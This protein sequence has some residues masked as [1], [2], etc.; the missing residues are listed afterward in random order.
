MEKIINDGY[1]YLHKQIEK[2]RE[3][4]NIYE[5]DDKYI[6]YYK[7]KHSKNEEYEYETTTLEY[8]YQLDKYVWEYD[9]WE[10][11]DYI[12]LVGITPVSKLI[13]IKPYY[14]VKEENK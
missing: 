10:G 4:K 2:L 8:D 11:E 7:L 1:E 5:Y 12:E 13:E 9:W 6:V 3:E 14:K